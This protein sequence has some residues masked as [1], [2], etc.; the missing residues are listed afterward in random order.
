MGASATPNKIGN[1]VV[2]NFLDARFRGRVCPVNPKYPDILGYKCFPDVGSIPGTVDLVMITIP[3][4]GVL[5]IMDECVKKK[6][7]GVIILSGGFEEINRNDPCWFREAY[8]RAES[9]SLARTRLL[10]PIHQ[11]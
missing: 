5:D 11:S 3:A 9:Q 4:E 7:G 10:Q 2:K 8:S 6:V 1:V